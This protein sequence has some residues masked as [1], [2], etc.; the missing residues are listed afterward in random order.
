MNNEHLTPD[1]LLTA[2]KYC[3]GD[4]GN[5]C[6]TGCPNAIP[7]TEDEYGLCDCRFSL[8]REVIHYLE[9]VVGGERDA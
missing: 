1:E 5:F 3:I 2:N 4:I 8:R 7:G 9:S 6:C